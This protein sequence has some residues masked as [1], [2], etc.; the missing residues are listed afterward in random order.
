MVLT[1]LKR[2]KNCK[3]IHTFGIK[4]SKIDTYKLLE[5]K[6]GLSGT[7]TSIYINDSSSLSVELATFW[8]SEFGFITFSTNGAR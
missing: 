3:A 5:E 1:S 8:A 4:P 7:V 6:I 2:P